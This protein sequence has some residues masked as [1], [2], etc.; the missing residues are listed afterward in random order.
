LTGLR[1]RIEEAQAARTPDEAAIELEAA[2]RELERLSQTIDEL[3]LLS[4]AGERDVPGEEVDLAEAAGAA[5]ERWSPAAGQKQISL[6]LRNGSAGH[7]FCARVDLDHAVD[8][9]IENALAYSPTGSTVEVATTATGID[10]LDRGPGLARGEDE[11]VFERFHRGS[12]ARSGPAGTGLG[13]PI[14]RELMRPWHGTVALRNRPGGGARA[15]I[16]LPG[17][18]DA[19]PPVT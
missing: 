18:T 15:R 11:A 13:L 3:L 14:A 16:E 19:L 17:I 2:T 1:L 10:V 12:A 8:A 4:R 7:A 6:A 5:V 9:V